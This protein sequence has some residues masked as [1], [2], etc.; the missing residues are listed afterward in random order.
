MLTA[1]LARSQTVR[2]G[3]IE[4]KRQLFARHLGGDGL[5]IGALQHPMTVPD[6][7]SIL[8]SDILTEEQLQQTYPGSKPPDIVSDSESFPTVSNDR[9]DFIIANHVLEHLSNPIRALAEWFRILRDDGLLFM[10]IPDKRYTFDRRRPRTPLAHLI[11]DYQSTLPAQELNKG[12]LLEWAEHVEQLAPGS[13]DF[14][15]WVSEQLEH[16]YSVHNHVWVAQD[17]LEMLHWMNGHQHVRFA[18]ERWCNSSPLRAEII[19]LLRA[20]KSGQPVDSGRFHTARR[21]ARLS[22]PVL[23]VGAVGQRLIAS[24][25]RS[26]VFSHAA[27]EA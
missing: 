7:S 4:A 22:H 6:A 19:V 15:R 14:E 21:I 3:F 16:G 10:A 26:R 25:R 8:Y 23:Q 20:R 24:A 13:A 1:G 9:F 17:I 27:K 2:R 18:L 11:S 5:E 12:H